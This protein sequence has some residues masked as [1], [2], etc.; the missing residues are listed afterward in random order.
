LLAS[1]NFNGHFPIRLIFFA[2]HNFSRLLEHKTLVAL[3]QRIRRIYHLT[4]LNFEE[5]REYIYFRLLYSGASGTPV[6]D[7]KAIQL[8]QQVS[9]GSP[10]LI[11]NLCDNCLIIASSQKINLIDPG[12]VHKAV[13]ISHLMGIGNLQDI[14]E[15]PAPGGNK[16]SAVVKPSQ[17]KGAKSDYQNGYNQNIST[18]TISP[19]QKKPSQQKNPPP[20]E[21]NV[22]QNRSQERPP[23]ENSEYSDRFEGNTEKRD[24][25]KFTKTMTDKIHEYGRIGVIVILILIIIFLSLY[26]FT[27]K[28]DKYVSE[29][30]HNQ[31]EKEMPSRYLAYGN[32]PNIQNRFSQDDLDNLKGGSDN[33]SNEQ[34]PFERKI[35]PVLQDENLM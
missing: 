5:T 11:N 20:S 28:S 31:I 18:G 6:F 7:D 19:D 8:I 2:H 35:H 16:I 1:S 29:I 24:K 13:E 10:R 26:I 32:M 4:G 34:L 14:K 12:I 3:G 33:L 15:K 23:H 27:S 22:Y 25:Q 17:G 21:R 30:Q 9:K